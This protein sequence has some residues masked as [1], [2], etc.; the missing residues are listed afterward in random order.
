MSLVFFVAAFDT[1]SS[2]MASINI[3][4]SIN[5]KLQ[6]EKNVKWKKEKKHLLHSLI[7]L[8]CASLLRAQREIILRFTN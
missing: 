4:L 5:T 8:N 7:L 1:K 6:S 3:A 2:L